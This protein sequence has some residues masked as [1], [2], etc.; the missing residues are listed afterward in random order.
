MSRT[1]QGNITAGDRYANGGISASTTRINANTDQRG[2]VTMTIP[3]AVAAS[4][5]TSSHAAA[6]FPRPP[7][8]SWSRPETGI[9]GRRGTVHKTVSVWRRGGSGRRDREVGIGTWESGTNRRTHSDY[10]NATSAYTAT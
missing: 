4:S 6:A 7:S 8:S 1:S 9:L 10:R 2:P 3:T 5:T